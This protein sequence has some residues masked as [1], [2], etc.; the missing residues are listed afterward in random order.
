MGGGQGFLQAGQGIG[1]EHRRVAGV[2]G[3]G[4]K[5]HDALRHG[6]AAHGFMGAVVHDDVNQVSGRLFGNDPQVA[7]VHQRR[8]VS[9]QAPDPAF[10]LG[11][12]NPQGDHG[13]MPHGTHGEEVPGMPLPQTLANL[14]QFPAQLARGGNEN[15]TFPRHAGDQ[16]HGLLPGNGISVGVCGAAGG[17]Q[18]TLADDQCRDFP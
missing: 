5:A 9:I 6:H 1:G 3:Q 16:P 18:R 12:G 17:G 2:Q 4:R 10:G 7:H 11:Q 13:S 15:I 14:K 8:A